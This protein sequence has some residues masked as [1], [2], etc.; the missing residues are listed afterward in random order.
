M[1]D[2]FHLD[3]SSLL[4]V[5]VVVVVVTIIVVVVVVI[6]V[7]II[8]ATALTPPA[9][10]ES[11]SRF[12]LVVLGQPSLDPRHVRTVTVTCGAQLQRPC[13]CNRDTAVLQSSSPSALPSSSRSCSPPSSSSA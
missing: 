13:N 5:F 8:I 9:E 4:L 10:I 6:I 7:V 12:R 11:C 3:L 2:L 1:H